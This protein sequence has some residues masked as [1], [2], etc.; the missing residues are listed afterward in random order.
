MYVSMKVNYFPFEHLTH[1][2]PLE[3]YNINA[4]SRFKYRFLSNDEF[5]GRSEKHLPTD[6]AMPSLAPGAFELH[7]EKTKI[8]RLPYPYKSN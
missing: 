2:V 3:I 4:S 7:I 8:S 5:H 1:K 6:F